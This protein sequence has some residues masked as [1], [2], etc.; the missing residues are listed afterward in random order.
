M[1][2]DCDPMTPD[3]ADEPTLGNDCDGADTD[4]CE[5]GKI[6]CVMGALT[7]SDATNDD[8]DVDIHVV[9][10]DIVP[11]RNTFSKLFEK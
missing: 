8:L 2:N 4:L 1:D 5:E 6:E 10:A 9:D 3:G 7:C 11:I